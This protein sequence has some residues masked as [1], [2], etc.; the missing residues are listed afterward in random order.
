MVPRIRGVVVCEVSCSWAQGDR[1][2]WVV[3]GLKGIIAAKSKFCKRDFK[4]FCLKQPLCCA[5][6]SNAA[7]LEGLVV[8]VA[9][10][11]Y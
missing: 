10:S 1:R 2:W 3:C 4:F 9:A 6:T 7:T 11:I 5:G 8:Q